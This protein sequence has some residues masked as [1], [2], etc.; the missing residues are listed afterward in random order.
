M[1]TVA[2]ATLTDRLKTILHGVANLYLMQAKPVGS[3]G[4][5]AEL[6]L[7]WSTATIRGEM[8]ELEEMGY[9]THSHTSSGRLPTAQGLFYYVHH[10]LEASDIPRA[11]QEMI[12][13]ALAGTELK[14]RLL[15][16]KQVVSLLSRLARNISLA[17]MANGER[18]YE[19]MIA[20]KENLLGQ[21]EFQDS[22]KLRD[23]LRVLEEEEVQA[24]IV[25]RSVS[26][27]RV[28]VSIGA[29]G[30]APPYRELFADLSVVAA[31]YGYKNRAL[32]SVCVIGPRRM[33]Y[34]RTI[35]LVDYMARSLGEHV[36][37]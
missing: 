13:V 9:L 15:L 31:P 17:M 10:L 20:G 27:D 2:T 37:A 19:Y 34:R 35:P 16:L 1:E 21:P 28:T 22:M 12:Q 14:D 5:Q 6:A 29:E 30:V 24:F 32:G 23:V 26:H 18:R 33:D 36:S 25:R 4:L 7:P 3:K 11:L 8:A